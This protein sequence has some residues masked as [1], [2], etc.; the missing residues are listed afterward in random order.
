MYLLVLYTGPVV[1]GNESV[2]VKSRYLSFL[3]DPSLR[4]DF[5]EGSSFRYIIC[6]FKVFFM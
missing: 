5:D 1:P 3:R 6:N 4:K 2:E